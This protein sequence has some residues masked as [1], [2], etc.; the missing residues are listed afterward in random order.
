MLLA[1][2]GINSVCAQS[3]NSTNQADCLDQKRL[4]PL[5]SIIRSEQKYIENN[6][7]IESIKKLYSNK[8]EI[9]SDLILYSNVLN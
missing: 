4:A 5:M 6:E 9:S 3:F 1:L 2:S 7:K 8:K